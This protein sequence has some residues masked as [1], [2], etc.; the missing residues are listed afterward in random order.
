MADA[1]LHTVK[2]FFYYCSYQTY[3]KSS[4]DCIIWF[5]ESGKCTNK[6]LGKRIQVA[7]EAFA[8]QQQN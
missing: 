1:T 2:S 6:G 3:L 5:I 7:R 8:L 4:A